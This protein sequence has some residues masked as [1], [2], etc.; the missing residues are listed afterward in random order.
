MKLNTIQ[1]KV[2]SVIIIVLICSITAISIFTINNSKSNLIKAATDTL[3]VNNEMLNK[4]IRNIMLSGEAPLARNTMASL[5]KIEEF[6]EIAIYRTD[7]TVAFHDYN[8]LDSVNKFQD[9]IEFV[10]TPRLKKQIIKNKYFNSVLESNTPKQV[11]IP[12]KQELEY[13]FPIL[14]YKECR[15][16]HGD[17]GFIRGI[18]HYKVS[19]SN[20]YDQIAITK[21][22]ST[23]LYTGTGGLIALFLIIILHRL[24]VSPILK[25]GKTVNIV[26]SGNLETSVHL[27]TKDEL[28]QLGNKINTMISGLKE[29]NRL[30]IENK[31]I[32][33]K[34]TENKKYL[35]NIQEGLLLINNQYIISDQYSIFLEKLFLSNEIAG[36]NFVDFLFPDQVKFKK[37]RA[38]LNEYLDLIFNNLTSNMDM[39][40][41]INPLK[42]KSLKLNN[43]VNSEKDLGEII[44]DVNFYRIMKNEDEVENVMIIFDDITKIKNVQ[45]QLEIEKIKSESEIEHIAAILKAGPEAF[46][47]FVDEANLALSELKNNQNN[48]SSPETIN[49]VF[50]HMHKLKGTARYLEFKHVANMAHTIEDEIAAIRDK[51]I[52]LDK[53]ITDKLNNLT[54]TIEVEIADI[55]KLNDR[56]K[57]FSAVDIHSKKTKADPDAFDD[58]LESMQNMTLDIAKQLKKD[59]KLE[60]NAQ[61][62]IYYVIKKL[63]GSIIHLIRNSIDHGIE[64]KIERVSKKKPETGTI[65]LKTYL[66]NDN[67][68]LIDITDD[69]MG[70]DFENIRKKAIVRKIIPEDSKD[71]TKAKLL[72]ILFT[73]SFSMKE[74]VTDISGR[75]VGLDVVKD[76]VEKLKGTIS[77]V[78]QK[79]KGTKFTLKIP[80]K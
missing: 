57:Q 3:S 23:V 6:K 5:K 19:I 11:E 74:N 49:N 70:I 63:K 75:G 42:E 73:P 38:D 35:N 46:I 37:E 13:F 7:G 17:Q 30:I 53:S 76:D 55:E 14:N 40:K 56:F 8:T 10:Q 60:I 9:K 48:L 1:I 39:F 45:K 31:V 27:K 66:D 34:N 4:V 58:F 68:F 59:V 20:V 67:H 62:K 26:G 28:G 15:T 69:G 18:A 33:A 29:K 47:D 41:D 43:I 36:K 78:S 22:I 2:V 72:K 44:V 32:D 61:S 64:D 77:V 25:I 24:V 71:I 21:K 52:T 65:R 80:L 79:G 50:R 54:K 51:K 16:C 12:E